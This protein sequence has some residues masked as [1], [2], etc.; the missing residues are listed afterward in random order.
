MFNASFLDDRVIIS[1]VGGGV[2]EF[3]QGLITN[4]IDNLDSSNLIY[5]LML[6]PQGKFL[7]DFFIWEEQ[8]RIFIDC[9][10]DDRE[11]IIQK[12][13][14]Y[15]LGK[16]IEIKKHDQHSI[17]CVSSAIS[18]FVDPRFP[19]Q[20][21][22]V[23]IE[24]DKRDSYLSDHKISLVSNEYNKFLCKNTLPDASYDMIK[25][26]SFPLEYGMDIYNAISFDKGCYVGQ[27]LVARTKYRGTIRK[28][29]YKISLSDNMKLEKGEE[30]TVS[31]QSIGIFC[32]SYDTTGK[33]L[34]R[35]DYVQE[36]RIG[37]NPIEALVAGS[38]IKII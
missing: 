37:S 31:G 1:L 11:E 33:A 27:E 36:L 9:L 34:L 5:S 26:R 12:L 35:K 29:I 38:V 28:G 15:K 3:L 17:L 21:S 20:T 8:G 19:G 10:L 32:S 18:S 25:G 22:R 24:N 14:L 2:R 30:V 23:Y 7:Y 13:T 6:T 4:N 16:D